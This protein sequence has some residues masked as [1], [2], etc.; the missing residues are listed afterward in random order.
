MKKKLNGWLSNLGS[1]TSQHL[2]V[3]RKCRNLCQ[4]GRMEQDSNMQAPPAL[5]RSGCGF[6]GNPAT[7]GMCSVC[8]K[9][10]WKLF[11]IKH[12]VMMQFQVILSFFLCR[13]WRRNNNHLLPP[14][15]AK[16]LQ[17]RAEAVQLPSPLWPQPAQLRL[18]QEACLLPHLRYLFLLWKAKKWVQLSNNSVDF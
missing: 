11:N 14:Q 17:L 13:L 4:A 7:D 12:Y 6:F 15:A 3:T 1:W 2:W 18:W 5:C 16:P 8:F 9:E 10:V